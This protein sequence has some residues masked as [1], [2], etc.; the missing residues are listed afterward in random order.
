M[1]GGI[2][3]VVYRGLLR[4]SQRG[5]HPEVFGKFGAVNIDMTK[6]APASTAEVRTALR[7]VFD[8]PPVVGGAGAPSAQVD[9][10]FAALRRSNDAA[11]ILLPPQ[12][13]LSASLPIFD[14][15]GSALM[16]GESTELNFFEPRYRQLAHEALDGSDHF[17]L[18]GVAPSPLDDGYIGASVLLKIVEHTVRPDGQVAVLV[19]AGPRMEVLQEEVGAGGAGGDGLT[20]ATE[21]AFVRDDD[22]DDDD[23]DSDGDT[24]DG[25]GTKDAMRA[26]CW[27]LLLEAETAENLTQRSLPPL[28]PERFSFWALS[29]LLSPGDVGGLLQWL[30]CRS[31]KARLRRTS[32][33]V[34]E[35][36]RFKAQAPPPSK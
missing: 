25:E 29:M 4:A 11:A 13:L 24:G 1:C 7:A 2:E 12:R 27:E 28:D 20:R 19:S 3:R 32:E 31:T 21:Y 17:L 22:D 15:A 9:D 14:F 10:M 18:R 34:R 16:T 5:R 6:P 8:L 33:M 35:F 30:S 26:R 36:L 23:S